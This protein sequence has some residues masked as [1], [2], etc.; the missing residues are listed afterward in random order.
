MNNLTE[1]AKQVLSNTS[2][3]V[4]SSVKDLISQFI[5]E[6]NDMHINSIEYFTNAIKILAV[7]SQNTA[8][9]YLFYFNGKDLIATATGAQP[10]DEGI[11]SLEFHIHTLSLAE[12]EQASDDQAFNDFID[13][14][15]RD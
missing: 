8:L 14:L 7:T 1:F 9:Q 11:A 4:P 6:S 2:S 15:Y 10:T 12:V 5:L 13:K 3:H